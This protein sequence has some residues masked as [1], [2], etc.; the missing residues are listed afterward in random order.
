MQE[1]VTEAASLKD[2]GSLV[3]FA[4]KPS[5]DSLFQYSAETDIP[6]C[7]LVTLKYCQKHK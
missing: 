3:A 5:P 6:S 4:V 7:Q 1:K 2:S